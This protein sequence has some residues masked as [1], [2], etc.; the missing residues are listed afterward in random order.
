MPEIPNSNC[1]ESE[2]VIG[3]LGAIGSHLT[4][5][6]KEEPFSLTKDEHPL[7]RFG[8]LDRVLLRVFSWI[9]VISIT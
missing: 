8:Y 3:L 5:H 2:L 6:L 7:Q 4:Q 9:D 1:V